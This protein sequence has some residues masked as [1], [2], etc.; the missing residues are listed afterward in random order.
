[1]R[2]PER[3]GS[4]A[5]S[6]GVVCLGALAGLAGAVVVARWRLAIVEVVG[7]SMS[8]AFADGDRVLALRGA[9]KALRPGRIVVARHR[10]DRPAGAATDWLVKR[11]AAVPGD[12]VPASVEAATGGAGRVPAGMVV[13][14]G[15]HPG[16]VDSRV[17]GFVPLADV[18]GVVLARLPA[19]P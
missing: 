13:L 12:R 18:E 14:L 1:V 19:A 7:A 4:A 11:V 9:R 16:S 17:W 3:R 5:W 6:P 8:P 15:D 10:G 2:A